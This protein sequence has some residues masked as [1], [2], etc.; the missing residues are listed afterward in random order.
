LCGARPLV[1][2]LPGIANEVARGM[3]SSEI[4]PFVVG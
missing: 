4:G 1:V 3:R 2:H